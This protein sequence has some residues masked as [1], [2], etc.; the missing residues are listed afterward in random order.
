MMRFLLSLCSALILIAAYFGLAGSNA[1]AAEDESIL[2][3]GNPP[4][5]REVSDSSAQVTVFMLK[6]VASGNASV[7]DF[8]LDDDVLDEWADSMAAEYASMSADEQQQLAI[9]P[10]LRG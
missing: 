2:A 7:S 1:N 6:V 8:A 10:P 3:P 4:L 5:T 9:M